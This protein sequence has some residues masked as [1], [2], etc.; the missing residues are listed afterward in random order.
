[1][2]SKSQVFTTHVDPSSPPK[3]FAT[4]EKNI[5]NPS[6]NRHNWWRRRVLPPGPQ[7]LF[8]KTFIAIVDDK[9]PT[10]LIYPSYSQHPSAAFC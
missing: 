8:H 5:H 4:A 10:R 9:A 1:M 2:P 6:L 7:R 3:K